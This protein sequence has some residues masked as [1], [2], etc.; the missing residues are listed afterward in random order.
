M[1]G[2]AV[3]VDGMTQVMARID[4]I[5]ARFGVP[6]VG[7]APAPAEPATLR[8]AATTDAFRLPDPVV[9]TGDWRSRLPSEASPWVDAIASAAT[10]HG[11]EPELLASLV[12]AESGFRPDAVSH[13][14]A[15]GLAQLMPGTAAGLGV[16]PTDP[17]Q[18]LDG[19]A[20]YLREQLDRFG[21]VRLALAAY[22]AG[23]N[24][25]AQAGGVPAIHETQT[26]V[27]RVLAY[28]DQ[29]R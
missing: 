11:L 7:P 20:R 13:A 29:L 6:A 12:W 26:Y 3:N 25:V 27:Q 23:P 4:T 24:R 22:N 1:G 15:T 16:D 21:D 28:R 10:R 18:N 5:R 19:G 17:I 9:A 2:P 14:G 8:A